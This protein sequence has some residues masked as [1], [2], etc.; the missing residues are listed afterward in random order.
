VTSRQLFL[1]YA[2]ANAT[3]KREEEKIDRRRKIEERE[4]EKKQ[5]RQIEKDG[6]INYVL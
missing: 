2:I 1:Y 6:R 3:G 4:R 5:V